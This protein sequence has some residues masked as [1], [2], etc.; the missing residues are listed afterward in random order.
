VP[1]PYGKSAGSRPVCGSRDCTAKRLQRRAWTIE[2]GRAP[3]GRPPGQRAPPERGCRP[4][5]CRKPQSSESPGVLNKFQGRVSGPPGLQYLLGGPVFA[6]DHDR[7]DRTR[8]LPDRPVE[9][10][11]EIPGSRLRDH[12][13]PPARCRS[14]RHPDAIPQRA[15]SPTCADAPRPG[16]PEAAPPD[17]AARSTSRRD[18]RNRLPPRLRRATAW[19]R[20]QGEHLLE[21][22]REDLPPPRPAVLRPH[23]HLPGPGRALVLHR[24]RGTGKRMAEI[25]AVRV[26]SLSHM[27]NATVTKT[28]ALISN[29]RR[30]EL[31]ASWKTGIR[32]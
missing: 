2:R 22:R 31:P 30:S 10:E 1:A 11:T 12:P 29:C 7:E 5:G 13:A 26:A 27:S 4:T 17:R 14:P 23:G 15:A 21:E 25:E 19:M 32:G 16:A 18:R 3:P 20:H 9:K 8:R 28:S 24:S 6:R